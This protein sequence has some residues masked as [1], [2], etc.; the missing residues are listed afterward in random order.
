MINFDRLTVKAAEAIQQAANT[1]RQSGNPAIED[2]H[3][4]GALLDQEEGIV[5]PMLQ[6]VGVNV[7]RLRQ[8]LETALGR[9]SRQSGGAQPTISRELNQILDRAEQEARDLKDEYISTEHLLLA[10]AEHRG[11]TT[12]ELL[13]AHGATRET[14]VQALAQVRGP[15]RVTDQNPEEKYQAL[16]RFSVDLT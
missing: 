15:H 3:L 6:K 1:A 12:R 4:L 5:V 10:L 7:T 2:L 9:L 13:S 11:S 16:Q 14:L 8:E